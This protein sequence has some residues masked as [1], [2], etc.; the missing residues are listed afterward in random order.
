MPWPYRRLGSSTKPRSASTELLASSIVGL[1]IG[2][3][4]SGIFLA[5]SLVL[6][7]RVALLSGLVAALAASLPRASLT[8]WAQ[9]ISPMSAFALGVMLM[10]K[11]EILAEIDLEWMAVTLMCSTAFAR[12]AVNAARRQPMVQMPATHGAARLASLVI[13]MLP[14]AVFAVS[15]EPVWGLWVAAGITLVVATRIKGQRWTS[16]MAVRYV[17]AETVFCLCVLLLMSAATI[18]GVQLEESEAS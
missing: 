16:P 10:A 15:P 12:A 17:A 2:G 11:F 8:P 5:A 7:T 4:A 1:V 18:T 13:G 14:L 9:P 6:P 3:L